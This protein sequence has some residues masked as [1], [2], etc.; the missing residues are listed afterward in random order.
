[1]LDREDAPRPAPVELVRAPWLPLAI[2]GVAAIASFVWILSLDSH[3][4]FIADDWMLLVKRQGWGTS[5]F[6][7]PFHGNIVTGPALVYKLMREVF[8]MGSATPYYA[9]SVATFVASGVLLFFHLRRRVGDWLALCGAVL[10][11]FLGAAFEDLLFA[12]Q[13]GY[14]ASVAAGL[15]MLIALDREDDAGDRIAC[16]LLVVSLAFS[17]IGLAFALGAL[18]DLVLGRR[19]RGRRAYVALAPIVLY[20]LWWLGWGH[21][22]VNHLSAHNVITS[23]EYVFKAAAAGITSLLGLASNDG[24]EPSQ[25]HLIWGKLILIAGLLLLGWKLVRERGISR[26]LA[27]ALAIGLAFWLAAAFNRDVSRLP[28]SSRFQYPSAVFLLLVAAEMIRGLRIPRPAIV[29]AV[30]IS[31]LA[32]SGGISLMHRE[33]H[34]R[35]VPYADALRSRLAALQ[36]AGTRADPHFQVAFPPDIEASARAYLLAADRYGSPAFSEGQLESRP[37][38]EREA[39]DVTLAQ[40]LGLAL[41]SPAKGERSTACQTLQASSAGYTGVTLLHGGFTLANRSGAGV[42][43]K[44]GR[45]AEGFPVSFGELP[46][47]V[48]TALAVPVDSSRRPWNLG[49]IGIGPVRLCTTESG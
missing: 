45:F 7:L 3:L 17:S 22:A 24:S 29:A 5:Y 32:I 28:T 23:P 18:V 38:G 9:L 33:Q 41:R 6:L 10:T 43:V 11:L 37:Q 27:M 13:I 36:I 19:P 25:P 2:L 21:A 1:M 31:G 8:G 16:A 20:A 15:G 40:A 46:A 39:A 14:Y 30:V 47:G 44:L 26:G 4:T 34:E 35:W 12:F 42:E 49:L 48:K